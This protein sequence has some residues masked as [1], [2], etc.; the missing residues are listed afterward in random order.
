[1]PAD[2]AL[3]IDAVLAAELEPTPTPSPAPRTA[4]PARQDRHIRPGHPGRPAAR[5][6]VRLLLAA[7]GCLA[8]LG[9]GIAVVDSANR[10][11]TNVTASSAKAADTAQRPADAASGPDFTA[12]QLPQQI[13]QLL[14]ERSPAAGLPHA[15]T[16]QGGQG[17]GGSST[18]PSCVRAAVG[19]HAADSPLTVGHG[20]YDATPVDAYVFHSATDPAQLDV[21]LL[22]P[23]C[24]G[25]GA[26]GLLLHQ[27]VPAH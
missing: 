16:A 10:V 24:S 19:G 26:A 12:A 8:V 20:R 15:A 9:L 14:A 7:T 17:E 23:G 3:R 21:Y 18:L 27:S 25:Q 22:T 4:P 2:V 6:R 11:S 13:Q 5:R 1:M